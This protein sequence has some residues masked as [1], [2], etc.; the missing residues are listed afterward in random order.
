MPRAPDFW[1]RTE[2]AQI[3]A[4]LLSPLGALYAKVVAGKIAGT[5]SV[6]ASIPVI[7]AGNITMGGVGKTPFVALL[8]NR[9]IDMGHAPFILMRGYGGQEKGPLRVTPAHTASDVGDEARMLADRLPVIISSDRPAGA[10]LA[11]LD[12]AS[13]IVMDDGF[14]NPGLAKDLSFVLI[15]GEAGLGNGHV[16]PAGPL[17]EHPEA[18]LK[19]A[20]AVVIVGGDGDTPLPENPDNL[21]VLHATLQSVIHEALKGTKAHAFSGIGR[22]EKFFRQ[23]SASGVNL[24]KEQGFPDHHAYAPHEI[25][26]LKDAAHK[27]GAML[28]T[29]EKDMARLSPAEAEGIT[30]IR[31]DM[32]IDNPALL[33][34]L[35]ARAA[36]EPT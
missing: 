31:A 20:Q 11:A 2:G 27:D 30:V 26:K 10:E 19:R 24:L 18:A 14:Q 12:G 36:G 6:R 9:L 7:C 21:P 1:Q 32:T 35:L 23:L 15:D 34:D 25:A 28:L 22:P 33:G 16:F 3:T 5:R 29:T 4:R 13:V 8:A 17:R